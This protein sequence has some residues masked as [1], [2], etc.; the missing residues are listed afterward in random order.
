M[1]DEKNIKGFV[2]DTLGCGCPESVFEYI[3]IRSSINI[4]DTI[5]LKNKLNIG[6]RLLIYV[7][8]VN[9]PVFIENNLGKIVRTGKSERDE[10]NFNRF[11][12]VVVT[13]DLSVRES[14]EQMFSSLDFLDDKIH[15][16]TIDH[17][18]YKKLIE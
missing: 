8:E 11:R 10:N 5:H 3:D 9:E 7:V 1:V 18:G 6:N 13:E 15:L 14:A 16:H 17:E 2:Q 12:L 4:D